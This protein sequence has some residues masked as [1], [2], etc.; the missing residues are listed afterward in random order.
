MPKT[1]EYQGISGKIIQI[2]SHAIPIV[3]TTPPIYLKCIV[4]YFGTLQPYLNNFT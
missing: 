2:G 4:D 3:S 1:N